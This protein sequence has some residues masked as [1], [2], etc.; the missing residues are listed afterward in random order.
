APTLSIRYH[1]TPSSTAT[2]CR[3]Y[4]LDEGRRGDQRDDRENSDKLLHDTSLRWSIV[5][6]LAQWCRRRTAAA[7]NI[8]VHQFSASRSPS[9][10]S[11]VV[12]VLIV[13]KGTTAGGCR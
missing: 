11:P 2:R 13:A 12:E 1:R 10:S 7:G 3:T 9:C 5:G 4:G 8:A 6:G